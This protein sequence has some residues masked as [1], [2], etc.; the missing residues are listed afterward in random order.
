MLEERDTLTRLKNKIQK[1]RLIIYI[2][3]IYTIISLII[4]LYNILF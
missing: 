1:Q 4:M 2:L 3:T